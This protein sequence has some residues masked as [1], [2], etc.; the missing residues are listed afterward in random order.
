MSTT[1]RALSALLSNIHVASQAPHSLL[2]LAATAMA[3]LLPSKQQKPTTG[4]NNNINGNAHASGSRSSRTHSTQE[5]QP[6]SFLRDHRTRLVLISQLSLTQL[7]QQLSLEA[8]SPSAGATAALAA[9]K[10][11]PS[12]ALP[13]LRARPSDVCMLA[14]AAGQA[15][16][17][18]RGYGSIEL[19]DAAQMQVGSHC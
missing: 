18:L 14:V 19:T 16:A 3:H 2:A 9:F 4:S 5:E 7:A 6:G 11:C 8:L 13:A 17:T 12:I 15:T 10:D 1:T